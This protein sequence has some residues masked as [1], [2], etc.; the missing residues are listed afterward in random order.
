MT[1]LPLAGRDERCGH[2]LTLILTFRV[3]AVSRNHSL[4]GWGSALSSSSR[5]GPSVFKV[6][7]RSS[8]LHPVKHISMNPTLSDRGECLLARGPISNLRAAAGGLER[9]RGPGDS[10]ALGEEAA[11]VA[12]RKV[13]MFIENVLVDL[14]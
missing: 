7:A 2:Y 8:A 3:M 13:N 11:A 10:G 12:R 4:I 14:E 6:E 9:E 5:K 1:S